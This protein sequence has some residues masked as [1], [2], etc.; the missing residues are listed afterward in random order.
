MDSIYTTPEKVKATL[1]EHGVAIIPNV[2]SKK[3]SIA[4]QRGMWDTLEHL[5]KTW[6]VPIDRHHPASWKEML[7][8]Y[9][10]H[11]MLH[12]QY[13]GHAPFIWNVRQ[14]PSCVH[15][16]SQL[17]GCPPEDL[18]CSFDGASFH[19]PHEVTGRG[20]YRN[21]WFHVDQSYLRNEFECVQSWVTAYE[22]RPGDATLCVLS[23]SHLYHKEIADQFSIREKEDWYK[24]ND[25]Q[26][27]AYREKGCEEIRITCPR[28]SMVLWD[29]RTVHCGVEPLQHRERYN[30]RCVAYLCY[31]PR[32]VTEKVLEKRKTIFHEKRMTSHWPNRPRVFGKQPRTY[33]SPLYDITPL[34]DPTLTD[35]GRRLVGF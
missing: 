1:Q 22:V 9:P 19:M 30:F 25:A 6:D 8:L 17:W 3:E 32:S 26:L 34:P 15:V 10:K 12:Q 27:A 13:I 21:A 14:H 16:F 28:G 20:Y 35:L 5:T 33:G 31:M 11:S 2:L 18:L 7:K 4:M 23:K 24:L 29:S